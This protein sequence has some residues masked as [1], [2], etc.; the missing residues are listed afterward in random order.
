MAD[1]SKF[2][3]WLTEEGLLR[4]AG[5]ARDGLTNEQIAHNMGIQLNTFYKW[6][7]K[8]TEFHDALKINKDVADRAIENALYKKALG[9]DTTAMIFWLKN[10]KYREWRD[11]RETSISGAIQTVPNQ[12][13][14]VGAENER[15]GKSDNK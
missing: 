11:R 12:L 5:W 6:K 8:Y 10:R 2:Q 1:A 15:D 4:V 3:D 14:F 9:G 7:K 13:T